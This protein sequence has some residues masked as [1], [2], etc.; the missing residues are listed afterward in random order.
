M[1]GHWNILK[2]ELVEKPDLKWAPIL[3]QKCFHASRLA[4]FYSVDHTEVCLREFTPLHT[5]DCTSS[6]V[7]ESSA[8]LKL[9]LILDRLVTQSFG[10]IKSSL[11]CPI[12]PSRVE[13]PTV[14][15]IR[16]YNQPRQ[17]EFW[18][19][20]P[21]LPA[22]CINVFH[23]VPLKTLVQHGCE[24]SLTYLRGCTLQTLTHLLPILTTKV[25]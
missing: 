1:V 7:S 5:L 11:T 22:C 8:V 16:G 19:L 17:Y 21:T 12:R 4:I 18:Q 6:Q 23:G 24:P 9:L 10:A 15:P 3:S 2:M 14:L 20:T 25:A 13:C